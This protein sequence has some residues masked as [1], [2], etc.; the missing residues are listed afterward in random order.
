MANFGSNDVWI[1]LG[2]G[3]G[4]FQDV[5]IFGAGINP[6]F[7]RTGDFNSNGATD[8]AVA[9][10]SSNDVSIL[11]GN[12]DGSFQAAVSYTSGDSGSYPQSLTTG[13]F[14]GN[15]TLDL[16]VANSG[17]NDVS[18][19]FGNGNGSFQPAANYPVGSGPAS[20]TAG[21]VNGDTYLD[22]THG[23]YKYE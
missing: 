17:L 8:L 2:N 16:A 3:D 13:D 5:V 6:T 1:L 9:N 23:E 15:G 18:V 20:I 21:D 10:S 4:S 22:L 7:I 14:N 12:G 19:L 11:M